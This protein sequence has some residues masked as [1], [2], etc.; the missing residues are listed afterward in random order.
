M[1]ALL[2]V[3]FLKKTIEYWGMGVQGEGCAKGKVCKGIGVQVNGCARYRNQEITFS[4]S[5]T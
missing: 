2:K 1:H 5:K 3:N 4:H